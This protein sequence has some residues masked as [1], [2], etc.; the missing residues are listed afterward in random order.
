MPL[1]FYLAMTEQEF[2]L[3]TQLPPHCGWMACHFSSYGKGLTNIPKALPEG[4]LL[5]VNDRTPPQGHDPQYIARQLSDAAN[6]LPI[7]GILLDLQRPHHKETAEIV[8]EILHALPCP[9]I[10]SHLYAELG[11][12][13][14]LLPPVPLNKSI[15]DVSAPWKGR[16]LWL[17]LAKDGLSMTLTESGCVSE[18]IQDFPKPNTLIDSTLHCHYSITLSDTGAI[19]YLERTN[20]DL[21][22]F[23]QEAKDFGVTA[24]VGLFQEFGNS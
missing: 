15:A 3:S 16:E 14:V 11:D 20:E 6:T 13:A 19:F 22:A 18:I 5:I 4:S 2:R 10:L 17:E 9:V 12:G 7:C 21:E 23:L 24:A 1:P 8:R